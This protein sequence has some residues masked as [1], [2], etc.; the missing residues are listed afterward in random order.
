MPSNGPYFNEI[1]DSDKEIIGEGNKKIYDYIKAV[2]FVSYLISTDFIPENVT[3][4]EYKELKILKEPKYK[5]KLNKISIYV[6]ADTIDSIALVWLLTW[7]KYNKLKEEARE[8]TKMVKKEG[9]IV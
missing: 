9:V 3:E 1:S 6:L 8:K 4:K 2:C 5:N 7:D